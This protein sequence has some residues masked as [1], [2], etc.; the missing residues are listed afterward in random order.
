[1]VAGSHLYA[2]AARIEYYSLNTAV[3]HLRVKFHIYLVR[4]ARIMQIRLV[5]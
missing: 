1:M 3:G 5:A 2:K 4:L